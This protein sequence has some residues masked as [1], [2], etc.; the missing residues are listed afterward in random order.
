MRTWS[1]HGCYGYICQMLSPLEMLGG[2]DRSPNSMV[3]NEEYEEYDASMPT[4]KEGL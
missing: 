4:V 3:G 2:L 1:T